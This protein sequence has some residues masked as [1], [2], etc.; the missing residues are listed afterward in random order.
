MNASDD[1][2]PS[3]VGRWQLKG[4]L[5]ALALLLLLAGLAALAVPSGYEG[6]SL[7][8]LDPMHEIRQADA[9]GMVLLMMGSLLSWATALAWQWRLL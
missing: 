6:T 7:W 3:T 4:W 9:V 5:S 1:A 2:G 8:I